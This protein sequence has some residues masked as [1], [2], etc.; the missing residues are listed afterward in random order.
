MITEI[1][2]GRDIYFFLI[3]FTIMSFVSIVLL[4]PDKKPSKFSDFLK[5][6]LL[7]EF[8]ALMVYMAFQFFRAESSA[9]KLVFFLIVLILATSII[10]IVKDENTFLN[11]FSGVSLNIIVIFM[12]QGWEAGM[13]NTSSILSFVMA[14]IIGIIGYLSNKDLPSEDIIQVFTASGWGALSVSLFY[15]LFPQ[16]IVFPSIG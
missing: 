7:G 9:D 8:G 15:Q 1:F 10:K 11:L 16:I 12:L 5:F 14:L 6:L 4:Y 2:K 3:L 13:I